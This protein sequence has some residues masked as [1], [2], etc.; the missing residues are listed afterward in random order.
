MT[1]VLLFDACFSVYLLMSPALPPQ[2]ALLENRVTNLVT[3]KIDEDVLPPPSLLTFLVSGACSTR[4]N[5]LR[6]KVQIDYFLSSLLNIVD[7]ASER[8][9]NNMK[10]RRGFD[11]SLSGRR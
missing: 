10:G 2:L 6:L 9:R 3:T 5:L 1:S 7:A 4:K 8:R 11:L